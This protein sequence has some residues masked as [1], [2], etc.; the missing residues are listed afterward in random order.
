MLIFVPAQPKAL[1]AWTHVAIVEGGR[2]H[3]VVDPLTVYLQV[4]H[5]YSILHVTFAL[6]DSS[7]QLLDYSPDN[8]SNFTVL[9]TLHGIALARA[10]LSIGEHRTVIA[11][12]HF[13]YQLCQSALAEG[14]LLSRLRWKEMVA[15]ECFLEIGVIDGDLGAGGIEEQ[16]GIAVA[17]LG[18]GGE[19]GSDTDG[20]FYCAAHFN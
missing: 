2:I 20:C 9:V 4:R 10:C 6:G 11:L 3:E 14:V 18:L 8:T 12:Q 17:L 15:P 16:F 19:E 13:F 5:R 7:E 1:D